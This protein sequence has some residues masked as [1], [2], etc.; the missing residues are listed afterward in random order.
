DDSTPLTSG[1]AIAELLAISSAS[2][3]ASLGSRMGYFPGAPAGGGSGVVPGFVDG[4][5]SV[6]FSGCTS[7]TVHSIAGR[8]SIGVA[9][10]PFSKPLHSTF[11]I[12]PS[13]VVNDAWPRAV[14]VNFVRYSN[15]P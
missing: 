5:D 1:A 2:A 9:A 4:L 3:V 10:P 6:C 13:P 14:K 7:E 11:E 15:T 8:F 12:L